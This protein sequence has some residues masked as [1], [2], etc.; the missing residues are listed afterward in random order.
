[1]T[2]LKVPKYMIWYDMIWYDM[3]YVP[4]MLPFVDSLTLNN[5]SSKVR[6][7]DPGY[8]IV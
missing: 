5:R 1:M 7:D 8:S 2:I 4:L 6:H 3:F